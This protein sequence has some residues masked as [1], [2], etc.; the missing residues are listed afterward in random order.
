MPTRRMVGGM[1]LGAALAR[2]W[3]WPSTTA[4]AQAA[5][6]C[7]DSPSTATA[8]APTL[9]DSGKLYRGTFSR[10]GRELWFF[11]KVG[12]DPDAEDYRIFLSRRTDAGWSSP[13][14]VALG[15]EFSDLYPT[16]SPDGRRLVFASYRRAPG[17]TAAEP[18][19]GLWSVERS[20]SGWGTPVFLAGV[21]R[22]GAYHS[23]P[24]IL[25]DGR[26]FFRRTSPN[27]DTTTTMVSSPSGHGFGPPVPYEPVERWHG[28]RKDYSLWGGAPTPD[29]ATV[30]LEVSPRP[31]G[32]Q[33]PGPSDLWVSRRDGGGWRLPA[34]LAAGVNTPAGWENFA[35]VSPDGCDL[36]FV[37]AFS[38]FYRVAL[39]AA[40]G[41]VQSP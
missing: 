7:R 26:L 22:L 11:K 40:I 6:H 2:G 19:A 8:F 12:D 17:D 18:N 5:G 30:L 37:R 3:I 14:R 13:E 20:D 41:A 21:T 28:W 31:D 33:R 29:G 23:Q 10:D 34:A 35:S 16:V 4:Q 39:G 27:W 25:P 1:L 36:I 38:A 9:A 15:G 32:Q 24:L